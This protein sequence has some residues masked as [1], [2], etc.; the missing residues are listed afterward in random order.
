MGLR[1]FTTIFRDALGPRGPERKIAEL[2]RDGL[3]N[4]DIGVRL[5]LSARTG[6]VAP[7]QAIHQAQDPNSVRAAEHGALALSLRRLKSGLLRPPR[8]S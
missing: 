1:A 6:R 7:A 5:F 8:I 2:A 3:S 4:P